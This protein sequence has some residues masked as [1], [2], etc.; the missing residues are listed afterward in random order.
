M[1]VCLFYGY[2][3]ILASIGVGIL[4]NPLYVN[5]TYQASCS[6]K[7]KTNLY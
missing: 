4:Q 6:I 2:F 3:K 7:K 1:P 5:L